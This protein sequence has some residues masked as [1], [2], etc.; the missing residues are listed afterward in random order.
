MG[1]E[2]KINVFYFFVLLPFYTSFE[3]MHTIFWAHP[4]IAI[5]LVVKNFARFGSYRFSS[6]LNDLGSYQ[7]CIYICVS[8]CVCHESSMFSA[9]T[10]ISKVNICFVTEMKMSK[11]QHK[12]WIHLINYDKTD[13]SVYST[14]PHCIAVRY[15]ELG[16]LLYSRSTSNR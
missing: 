2:A 11:W 10:S 14:L 9:Q 1:G 5:H 16:N 3:T 12:T 6:N 7:N 8:Y 4:S 15:F 13:H